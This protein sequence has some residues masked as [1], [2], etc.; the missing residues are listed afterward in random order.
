M[1]AKQGKIITFYSYK[2]GVGRTMILANVA[3][4][5]ASNG[6]KVLMVDWDL[7]APG[8]HRY[9]HPFLRD[10]DLTSTEGLIDFLTDFIDAAFTPPDE[11][12]E[13]DENWHVPFANILRFA[14]SLDWHFPQKGTIDFV[15][16][17]RQ[18]NFYSTH[19]NS[20]NWDRFYEIGGGRFLETVKDKMRA[21]YD[22]ILIDSRTGISDTSGICTIQMPDIL[23]VIFSG[24]DQSIL[25]TAGVITSINKQWQ[26]YNK[27]N[28][29]RVIFPVFS[30]TDRTEK[31]KLDLTRN[32]VKSKFTPFLQQH[33]SKTEVEDYWRNVEIPY[34]SWYAYEEVLATFDET[35]EQ[36]ESLLSAIEPFVTFLTNKE[37][38]KLVAPNKKERENILFQFAR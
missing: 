15:P 4:I 24:N 32:Y 10:K 29:Q 13:D 18:G 22:Y 35:L 2:G 20:F 36:R 30:R 34:I 27:N 19:V 11:T 5:L 23:V 21:D 31:N 28:S 17:G 3:W 12:E 33:L 38:T 6:K 26:A 14:V 25:G 8:L 37:V 9:F 7:E 16:A 1:S